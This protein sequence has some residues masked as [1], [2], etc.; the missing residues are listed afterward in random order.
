MVDHSFV[1]L[2]CPAVFI[3][4]VHLCHLLSSVG[5]S[6]PESGPFVGGDYSYKFFLLFLYPLVHHLVSTVESLGMSILE[7]GSIR[8]NSSPVWSLGMSS[9][10]KRLLRHLSLLRLLR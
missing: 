8:V 7:K 4:F 3:F 5:R 6:R 2:P 1:K 9:R 10:F